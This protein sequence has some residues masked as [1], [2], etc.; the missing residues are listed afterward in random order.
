ME[1]PPELA[2]PRFLACPADCRAL[3]P[4]IADADAPAFDL[5][6][7]SFLAILILF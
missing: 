1:V 6:P 5:D 7:E 4:D 2:Y 3:N